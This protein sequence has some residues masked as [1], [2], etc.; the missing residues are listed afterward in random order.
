VQRK[1]NEGKITDRQASEILT[2]I[3]DTIEGNLENI[4]LSLY[5]ISEKVVTDSRITIVETECPHATD[6]LHIYVADKANCSHFVTADEHLADV[7]KK[8]P[9]KHKLITV[10]MGTSDDLS[11]LFEYFS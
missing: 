3:A 6:A 8:S 10:Y 4:N 11:K 5:P 2:G 7:L 1:K 9:L